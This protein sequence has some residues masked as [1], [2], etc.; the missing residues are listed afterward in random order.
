MAHVVL[1]K[2]AADG[3]LGQFFEQLV[4]LEGKCLCI[5]GVVVLLCDLL[6]DAVDVLA[7]VEVL[8]DPRYLVVGVLFNFL[9]E[10]HR[11]LDLLEDVGSELGADVKQVAAAAAHD[12]SVAPV[13]GLSVRVDQCN[14]RQFFIRQEVA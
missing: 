3:E 9:I 10:R 13:A 11:Y 6:T 5:E 7:V 12:D 4:A 8:E 1:V 14:V 2:K